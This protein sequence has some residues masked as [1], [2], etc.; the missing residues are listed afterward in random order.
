V[1]F[2][3][4]FVKQIAQYVLTT[5]VSYSTTACFDVYTSSLGT[6]YYVSQSYKINKMKT[7]IQVAV[8]E[9]E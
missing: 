7:F 6:S 8:T 3:T 5:S 9:N 2:V 1:F 4:I